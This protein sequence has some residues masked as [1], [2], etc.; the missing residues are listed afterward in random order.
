[1][2]HLQ[3]TAAPRLNNDMGSTAGSLEPDVLGLSKTMAQHVCAMFRSVSGREPDPS[4]SFAALGVDSLGAILFIRVLSESLGGM[5]I[6]PA[7]LHAPGITVRSFSSHLHRR[8]I[9]EKPTVVRQLGLTSY[10]Q[11]V[12]VE[13]GMLLQSLPDSAPQVIADPEDPEN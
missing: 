8:L 2:D 3:Q 12:D 5:R 11:A 1:M 7:E 4:S 10:V 6:S 13:N 9:E